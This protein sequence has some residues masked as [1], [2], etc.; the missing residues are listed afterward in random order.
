MKASADGNHASATCQLWILD[1]AERRAGI[2]YLDGQWLLQK[3]SHANRQR[4]SFIKLSQR[5]FSLLDSDPAWDIETG[6]YKGTPGSPAI[7]PQEQLDLEDEIFDQT[8]YDQN[9]CWCLY[10]VLLV[11]W[12]KGIAYRVGI[13]QVHIHAFDD[14]C[15]E[16]R[17]I[18]LG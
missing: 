15:P 18:V 14:A 12:V 2:V 17:T 7:N 9:I 13:G 5:I 11:E 6:S 3:G 10:S 1:E 4:F 8:V 16:W